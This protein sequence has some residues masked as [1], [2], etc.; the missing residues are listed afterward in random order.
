MEI[1]ELVLIVPIHHD[2]FI[3]ETTTTTTVQSSFT[4]VRGSS[5][6]TRFARDREK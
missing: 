2:G 5:L 1:M 4:L 3:Q 6:S